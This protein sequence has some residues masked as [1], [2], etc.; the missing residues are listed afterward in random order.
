MKIQGEN[1]DTY[2]VNTDNIVY[3]SKDGIALRGYGHLTIPLDIE[4]VDR[5]IATTR[6]TGERWLN[7]KID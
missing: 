6:K 3:I 4:E 1:G 7:G 5:V 2:L